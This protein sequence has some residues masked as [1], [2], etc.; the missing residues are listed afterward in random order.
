M[1]SNIS[2][3]SSLDFTYY[4]AYIS[5]CLHALIWKKA[6]IVYLRLFLTYYTMIY[7]VTADNASKMSHLQYS[8]GN[9]MI[10]SSIL[11]LPYYID[12]LSSKVLHI[13]VD[14]RQKALF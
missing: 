13:I 7:Y 1:E 4:L 8:R 12:K 14:L 2:A 3:S 11:F 6:S 5:F 9:Y 10:K